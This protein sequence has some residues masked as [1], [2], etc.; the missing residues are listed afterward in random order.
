M[1]VSLNDCTLI[2]SDALAKLSESPEFVG[3]TRMDQDS[4]YWMV[5]KVDGKLYKTHNQL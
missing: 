2:T 5:W 1:K 4:K 3:Q